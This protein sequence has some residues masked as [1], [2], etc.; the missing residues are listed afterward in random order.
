MNC[1]DPAA[2]NCAPA[3]TTDGSG[4]PAFSTFTCT[5]STADNNIALASCPFVK[6]VCGAEQEYITTKGETEKTINM[7]AMLTKEY[8]CTY[9][10]ISS[11]GAPGFKITSAAAAGQ[12]LVGW[13]E[14][15]VNNIDPFTTG[16]TWPALTQTT[17][18]L[19][20]GSNCV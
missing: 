20:C 5:S 10:I 13:V 16:S 9:K 17:F 4:N 8:S 15:E 14:Y 6:D 7:P 11:T 19:E 3:L 12:I 18:F 2:T 1:C